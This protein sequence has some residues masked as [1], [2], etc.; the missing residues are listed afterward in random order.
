MVLSQRQYVVVLL[1]DIQ[2][3]PLPLSLHEPTTEMMKAA[4]DMEHS[5]L[6][7][8]ACMLAKPS[9]TPVAAHKHI[10][11]NQTHRL[12]RCLRAASTGCCG[13]RPLHLRPMPPAG[14]RRGPGSP[15]TACWEARGQPLRSGTLLDNMPH[16]TESCLAGFRDVHAGG[17]RRALR[18]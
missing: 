16:V 14:P 7:D 8:E 13:S 2:S 9:L 18:R 4:E 11:F 5:S 12:P 6:L 1:Q 3:L 10:T 15:L 17:Q